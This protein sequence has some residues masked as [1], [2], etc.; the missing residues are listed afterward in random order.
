[1]SNKRLEGWEYFWQNCQVGNYVV[2]KRF[3]VNDHYKQ[4]DLWSPYRTLIPSKSKIFP[5]F[6]WSI[7][8]LTYTTSNISTC[9]HCSSTTTSTKLFPLIHFTRLTFIFNPK[10]SYVLQQDFL[11]FGIRIVLK[12]AL[13]MFSNKV[14]QKQRKFI[15]YLTLDS[16]F[17]QSVSCHKSMIN[18]KITNFVFLWKRNLH[19][20][21]DSSPS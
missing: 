19:Y 12:L 13:I 16:S 14:S 7:L 3:R 9:E 18:G 15:T 4:V 1:M 5:Q 17:L 8:Y 20:D 21:Y 6:P 2:M 10:M 11:W